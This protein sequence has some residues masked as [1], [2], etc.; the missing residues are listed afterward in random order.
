MFLPTSWP[1][2]DLGSIPGGDPARSACVTG[3]HEVIAPSE[4]PRRPQ[5]HGTVGTGCVSVGTKRTGP[6]K[7]SGLA[8]LVTGHI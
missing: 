6:R 1:V 8:A 7:A 5:P 2:G 3:L 4:A